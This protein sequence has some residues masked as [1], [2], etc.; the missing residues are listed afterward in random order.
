MLKLVHRQAVDNCGK[1]PPITLAVQRPAQVVFARV[2]ILVTRQT[3]PP[4]LGVTLNLSVSRQPG[5][6]LICPQFYQVIHSY[7]RFIHSF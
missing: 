4:Y 3:L 6:I 7:S 2:H 1:M 5:F